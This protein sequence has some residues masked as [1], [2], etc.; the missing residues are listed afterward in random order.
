[1]SRYR[2]QILHYHRKPFPQTP[3]PSGPSYGIR[4]L[5]EAVPRW[6]MSPLVAFIL[7]PRWQMSPLMAFI[8][9]SP[10]MMANKS[11]CGI[12]SPPMM[13]NVSARGL[14]SP[15]MMANESANESR[16][17]FSP[18]MASCHSTLFLKWLLIP[19]QSLSSAP[20]IA[21]L[22]WL[23]NSLAPFNPCSKFEHSQATCQ[24]SW[25]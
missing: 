23:M 7:L 3:F 11:A 25:F 18:N 22:R 13:A 14:H 4:I 9:H 1:M 5:G 15:P 10:P 8:I 20:K 2:S 17:Y 21:F 19:V 6:L 16:I 24:W 12:H